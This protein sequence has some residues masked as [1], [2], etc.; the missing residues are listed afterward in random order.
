MDLS[1]Y[2]FIYLS[3]A[4]ES[5]EQVPHL[6]NDDDE[7]FAEDGEDDYDD[8]DD[9]D[10]NDNDEQGG[11]FLIEEDP[12]E[13]DSSRLRMRRASRRIQAMV[14]REQSQEREH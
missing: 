3:P 11:L 8:D 6:N 7:V 5:L 14:E 13:I 4:A 1:G 12:I 9:E 2:K 10:D